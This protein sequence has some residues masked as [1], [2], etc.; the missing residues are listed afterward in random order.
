MDLQVSQ[1]RSPPAR[2]RSSWHVFPIYSELLEQPAFPTAPISSPLFCS[3]LE[4]RGGT[5]VHWALWQ[6]QQSAR[7]PSISK[8]I[9]PGKTLPPAFKCR[10]AKSL[11]ISNFSSSF[12]CLSKLLPRAR[13]LRGKS[14]KLHCSYLQPTTSIQDARLNGP[15]SI[16][17]LRL[18]CLM[19][20]RTMGVEEEKHHGNQES[21]TTGQRSQVYEQLN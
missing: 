17:K 11:S 2:F 15:K 14:W 21:T 12:F 20:E 5:C 16:L 8:Y 10:T 7:D 3:L 19:L 13:P 9:L 4:D 18:W 1:P 6:L